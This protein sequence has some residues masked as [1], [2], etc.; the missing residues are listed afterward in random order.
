MGV[1]E[2]TLFFKKKKKKNTAESFKC[3]FLI[4]FSS[5]NVT[6]HR[7]CIVVA[8]EVDISEVEQIKP[9]TICTVRYQKYVF[10]CFSDKAR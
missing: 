2:L 9:K 5:D 8:A 10:V 4:A 7:H 3:H 1:C 6:F